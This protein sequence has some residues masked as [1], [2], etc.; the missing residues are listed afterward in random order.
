MKVKD[1]DGNIYNWQIKGQIVPAYDTRNRSQLHLMARKLLYELFPTIPILEEVPV[2]IIKGTTQY[3]DFY[4]NTIK[5][6][7]EPHG[8]QHYK[9]NTLFHVNAHDFIRQ[10][11]LDQQKRE[12]CKLNGLTYI[13]LPFNETVDQWRDRIIN[14]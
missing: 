6:V 3:F 8:A 14:R 11:K 5:L 9:F 2:Q 4:L 12:W 7:V 13:E 10:R 1:L